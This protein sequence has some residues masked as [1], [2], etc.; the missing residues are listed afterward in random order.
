MTNR[1]LS[2]G[3]LKFAHQKFAAAG[4]HVVFMETPQEF[5]PGDEKLGE[6][7]LLVDLKEL[8]LP[9]QVAKGYHASRPFDTVLCFSENEQS[10]AAHIGK[11]LQLPY[12]TEKAVALSKDKALMREAFQSIPAIH[13]VFFRLCRDEKDVIRAYEDWHGPLLV[14]PRNS[15]SSRGVSMVRSESDIAE[16]VAWVRQFCQDESFLVEEYLEG[17]EVSVETLTLQDHHYIITITDKMTTGHPHFVEVG[18][19]VPSRH[20]L[21]AQEAIKNQVIAVS[22]QI[23]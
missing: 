12:T 20:P 15:S 19:T 1:I 14:K 6:A 22:A 4:H 17:P 13:E 21:T 3:R 9:T 11:T 2:I 8:Q 16:A 5:E 23:I 10:I 18:H 7:L